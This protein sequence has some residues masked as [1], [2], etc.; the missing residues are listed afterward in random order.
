M[1]GTRGGELICRE[2]NREAKSLPFVVCAELCPQDEVPLDGKVAFKSLV[3]A[4]ESASICDVVSA[5]GFTVVRRPS[6]GWAVLPADS[7]A[8]SEAVASHISALESRGCGLTGC[9][10]WVGVLHWVGPFT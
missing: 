1:R 2:S 5:N 10:C 9:G 8:F 4:F 7:P 6:F 3:H